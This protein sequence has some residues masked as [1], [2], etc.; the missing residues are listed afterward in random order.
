[1]SDAEAAGEADVGSNGTSVQHGSE[2]DGPAAGGKLDGLLSL[3][4]G[5]EFPPAAEAAMQHLAALQAVM[6][7]ALG[8][9]KSW[10]QQKVIIV[11]LQQRLQDAATRASTSQHKL[12]M[13]RRELQEMQAER[14]QGMAS[15]AAVT[16]QCN[17]LAQQLL[18]AQQEL[19]AAVT[20]KQLLQQRLNEALPEL[21]GNKD[22]IQKLQV[23]QAGLADQLPGRQAVKL[24]LAPD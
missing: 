4:H 23:R 12:A 2:A 9:I 14:E 18:Q 7:Q 13:A 15:A 5:S 8:L 3:V 24:R 19:A 1:V 17:Q 16:E 6:Q 20:D 10:Q 21:A 11:L 22:M